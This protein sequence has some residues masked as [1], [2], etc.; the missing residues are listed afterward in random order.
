[1]KLLFDEN[2]S[3]K[4]VANLA[5]EYPGSTHALQVGLAA[6]SDD[7]VWS[8]A[9]SQGF[10]IVSKDADFCQRSFLLGFPPKVIWLAVGNADTG[11]IA[12]LLRGERARIVAFN[13]DKESSLLVLSEGN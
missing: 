11:V 6:A 3:V 12:K 13:R 8:Y 9:K 2:V 10:A 7:A 4:L 1:M 5:A